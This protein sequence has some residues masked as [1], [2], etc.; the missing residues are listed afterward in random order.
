MSMDRASCVASPAA[1]GLEWRD[2]VTEPRQIEPGRTLMVTTRTFRR[3]FFLTPSSTVNDVMQ[4]VIG[5]ACRKHG[6]GLVSAVVLSNH[7]HLLVNDHL[8]NAPEF[9]QTVNSLVAR[10]LNAKRGEHGGMFARDNVDLKLVCG[11]AAAITAIAYL[12]ANPVAAACVEHGRD[13]PGLRS[14][15][16][17]LARTDLEVSRPTFFMAHRDLGY[18]GRLPEKVELRYELPLCVAEADRGLFVHDAE[19]ALS[20]AEDKARQDVRAAGKTFLGAA[21]CRNVDHLRTAKSWE[22]HGPNTGPSPFLVHDE[23]EEKRLLEELQLFLQAYALAYARFKAG[24]TTVT[25][26]RGT[27]RL[28]RSFGAHVAPLGPAVGVAV[29]V[30]AGLLP[31]PPP[32]T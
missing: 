23:A 13:W 7:M 8:G 25:F 14:Q 29:P 22:P 18:R 20:A 17:Q 12:G 27:Y 9:V 1:R 24:D 11:R 30:I 31:A 16:R 2:G 28:V 21:R 32:F 6:V 3:T 4:Y 5:Y 15:P 10:A 26:P 19:V